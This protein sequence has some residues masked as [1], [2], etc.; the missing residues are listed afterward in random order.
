MRGSPPG[1]PSPSSA[2]K[3]VAKDDAFP[4]SHLAARCGV[5]ETQGGLVTQPNGSPGTVR[6]TGSSGRVG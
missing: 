2:A 4:H 3:E 1:A 6:P 5:A